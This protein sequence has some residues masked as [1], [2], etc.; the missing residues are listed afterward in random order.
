MSPHACESIK[1]PLLDNHSMSQ[2]SLEFEGLIFEKEKKNAGFTVP[3]FRTMMTPCIPYPIFVVSNKKKSCLWHVSSRAKVHNQLWLCVAISVSC[4]CIAFYNF[5]Q[6]RINE[7]VCVQQTLQ[8]TLQFLAEVCAVFKW[9]FC[10]P[11][12]G[13]KNYWPE[14]NYS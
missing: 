11:I 2:W 8:S 13:K 12:E 4:P 6:V 14:K 1:L 3:L 9:E 10:K 5:I 7:V